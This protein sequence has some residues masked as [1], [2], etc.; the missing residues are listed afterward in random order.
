M[1]HL[2]IYSRIDLRPE[3]GRDQESLIESNLQMT[4]EMHEARLLVDR[5]PLLLQTMRLCRV[6][7]AAAGWR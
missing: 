7:N 5:G 6:R 2:N 3:K 1:A 4:R